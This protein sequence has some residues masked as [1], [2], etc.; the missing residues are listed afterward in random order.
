MKIHTLKLG[1]SESFLETL[2]QPPN[3][4]AI[5]MAIKNLTQIG[6]LEP[7]VETLTPLGSILATLPI[8]ARIG[9]NAL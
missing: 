6:A 8:D 9:G 4:V 3:P 2:P 1:R 7:E 5:E